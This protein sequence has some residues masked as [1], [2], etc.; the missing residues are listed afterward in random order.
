MTLKAGV[1]KLAK[2]I[3]PLPISVEVTTNDTTEMMEQAKR[4]AS[5]GHNVVVKIPVKMNSVFPVTGLS[6]NLRNQG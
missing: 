1:K 4:L 2:L 5:L 6:I 3:D